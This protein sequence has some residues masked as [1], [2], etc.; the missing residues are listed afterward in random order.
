MIPT[1]EPISPTILKYT[2]IEGV[3]LESNFYHLHFELYKV[4]KIPY[5]GIVGVQTT[6]VVSS[7]FINTPY[8]PSFLNLVLPFI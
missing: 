4:I 3:G 6:N 7:S 1:F 2:I 8:K 5:F